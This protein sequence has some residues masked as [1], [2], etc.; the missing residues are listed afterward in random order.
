MNIHILGAHNSETKSTKYVS[1]LI[2]DKLLIDTGGLTS[3]LSIESQKKI[4]AVLLTHKHYD[5]VRDLPSLAINL[6]F[7]KFHTTVHAT[8]DVY[9]A[10]VNHLLNNILYP[11]F[12]V[13]P[14]VKPTLDYYQIEPG[15][16]KKIEQYNVLPVKMNHNETTVGYQITSRD[17]KSVFYTSDTGSGLAHCWELI[18]PDLLLIEVTVPNRLHE[19]AMQTN[20]L[21]PKL[22]GM[23][24]QSF[25]KI[26]GYLPRIVAIH[27]NPELVEDIKIELKELASELA[28]PIEIAYEGMQIRI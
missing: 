11:N 13:V 10:I 25:L 5:H 7:Q 1:L 4:K 16:A 22:L 18:S 26:H 12:F 21:T 23:E 9:E 28:I 3:S 2:D 6:F 8:E 17:N 24:L 15:L 19:F 20:H 14:E 27:M